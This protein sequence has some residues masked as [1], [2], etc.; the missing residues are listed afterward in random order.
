[1]CYIKGFIR[2]ENTAFNLS[3][4]ADI[5]LRCSKVSRTLQ[6]PSTDFLII[7]TEFNGLIAQL[8]SFKAYESCYGLNM[9][10]YILQ[11]H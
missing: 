1:M 11:H 7:E 5:S 2:Y 3:Y 4:R 10:N 8:L 6:L 9:V